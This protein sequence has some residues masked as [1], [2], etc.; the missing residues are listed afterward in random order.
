MFLD[1]EQV[2]TT[3][4]LL[5]LWVLL[6]RVQKSLFVWWRLNCACV[7]CKLCLDS[8]PE[9]SLNT[10]HI[11]NR[12]RQKG[13]ILK[14]NPTMKVQSVQMHQACCQWPVYFWNLI[15]WIWKHF[16]RKDRWVNAQM[17]LDVHV[18]SSAKQTQRSI[19]IDCTQPALNCFMKLST[20][21]KLCFLMCQGLHG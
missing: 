10:N 17:Q 7:P 16:T 2:K 14:S 12:T 13:A 11:R 9:S 15:S 6:F 1:E 3:N 8:L 5:A 18:L 19:S 4:Y 21:V 20:T